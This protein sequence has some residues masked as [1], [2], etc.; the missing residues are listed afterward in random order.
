MQ[1]HW[2][3]GVAEEADIACI[4]I[5]FGRQILGKQDAVRIE[6]HMEIRDRGHGRLWLDRC[7]VDQL[8]DRDQLAVDEDRMVRRKDEIAVW[9]TIGKRV[10]QYSNRRDKPRIGVPVEPDGPM[11][12]PLHRSRPP[13]LAVRHQH[14]VACLQRF[15]R[16]LSVDR[17][18]MGTC[19]VADR[20]GILPDRE[21]GRRAALVAGLIR[22]PSGNLIR[23]VV[24]QQPSLDLDAVG[25]DVCGRQGDRRT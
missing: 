22:D 6:G 24:G 25:R 13:A 19:H 10:P 2:H 1:D 11:A 17:R 18:D 5:A 14:E 4:Q 8:T 3:F 15:D 9:L 12:D 16:L 23:G 20:G 7:T 21:G